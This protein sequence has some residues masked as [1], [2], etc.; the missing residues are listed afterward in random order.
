M[1]AVMVAV[2]LG[3]ALVVV[4]VAVVL[5]VALV[6]LMV[7]W[8]WWN[9]GGSAVVL[10]ALVE[11]YIVVL[12]RALLV[13]SSA[14]NIDHIFVYV[15]TLCPISLLYQEPSLRGGR[16]QWQSYRHCDC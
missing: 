15:P 1:V 7:A 3:L 11:E 10:V 16:P 9:G 5:G 14:I 13:Q 12:V 4:M 2:V 8:W 6:A